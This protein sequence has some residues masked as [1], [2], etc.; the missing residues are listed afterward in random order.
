MV[1]SEYYLCLFQNQLVEHFHS[2]NVQH[3]SPNK[4]LIGRNPISHDYPPFQSWLT[5]QNEWDY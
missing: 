5:R 3:R 1:Q 2:A 4:E